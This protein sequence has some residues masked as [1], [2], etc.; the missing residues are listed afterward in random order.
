[1]IKLPI[2]RTETLA[3][4]LNVAGLALVFFAGAALIGMDLGSDDFNGD[5]YHAIRHVHKPF[6]LFIHDFDYATLLE[7]QFW[8]SNRV[9][10]GQLWGYRVPGATAGILNLFLI[11]IMLYRHFSHQP[12]VLWLVA[13]VAAFSFWN[14]WFSRW[15]MANYG[16]YI[17]LS[18]YLYFLFLKL[19]KSPLTRSWI[20]PTLILIILMPWIYPT[21]IIPFSIG[22]ALVFLTRVIGSGRPW[23]ASAFAALKE[24]WYLVTGGIF[25]LGSVGAEMI[26][27]ADRWANAASRPTNLRY[28]FSHADYTYNFDGARD[29]IVDR[30]RQLFN[31]LY[32]LNL[33]ERPL[34][35]IGLDT[36]PTR[37]ITQTLVWLM[38][39]G[40]LVV[41]TRSMMGRERVVNI[42]TAAYVVLCLGVTISLSLLDKFAYGTPRYMMFLLIPSVVLGGLALQT[43]LDKTNNVLR[44]FRNFRN[45]LIGISSLT[46]LLFLFFVFAI[47]RVDS[48]HQQRTMIRAG[49]DKLLDTVKNDQS[50]V[51]LFDINNPNVWQVS[52]PKTLRRAD[53]MRR[54]DG[55][56]YGK[57]MPPS[58]DLRT[59]VQNAEVDSVLVVTDRRGWELS[60]DSDYPGFK[61][62]FSSREY[63]VIATFQ[64][65]RNHVA[66]LKRKGSKNRIEADSS[67]APLYTFDLPPRKIKGIRIDPSNLADSKYQIHNIWIEKD[68]EVIKAQ[69]DARNLR[70]IRLIHQRSGLANVYVTEAGKTGWFAPRAFENLDLRD[71]KIAKLLIRMDIT[72]GETIRVFIDFG[73]GYSSK[74][75]FTQIIRHNG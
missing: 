26:F 75:S 10:D 9:F 20:I 48:I 21:L 2:V 46:V 27:N 64:R 31:D 19:L 33:G 37:W 50:D 54:F 14:I 52:T 12:A 62:L 58:F 32:H 13:S 34:A 38:V 51:V 28:Y 61:S 53:I 71:A 45:P 29:F 65:D 22:S 3:G 57:P 74:N 41:F 25:F 7:I 6:W 11:V 23:G 44:S 17:F 67:L 8:L 15:G 30:T 66:K 73:E 70:L 63:E 56:K 4:R 69:T 1:M 35:L 47:D 24:L 68:G 36:D 43:G 39:L 49:Y 60:S 55:T 16:E 59:R 5:T 40:I 18:S 72:D 42:F